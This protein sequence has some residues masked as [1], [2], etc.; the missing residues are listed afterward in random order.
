MENIKQEKNIFELFKKLVDLECNN[1][2]V[3]A[4][5][6]AK[7]GTRL[8][9]NKVNDMSECIVENAKEYGKKLEF[10]NDT[11]KIKSAIEANILRNYALS[12]EKVNKQFDNKRKAIVGEEMRWQARHTVASIQLNVVAK[13][14]DEAKKAPEYLQEKQLQEQA[15]MAIDE[16]D[17]ETLS[18]INKELTEISMRNPATKLEAQARQIRAE[19]AIIEETIGRCEK[20]IKDCE[21]ERRNSIELIAGKKENLLQTADKKYLLVLKNEGWLQRTWG[22]ILNK[23]NGSK[24][25]TE[26]VTNVLSKKV[27]DIDYKTLPSLKMKLQAETVAIMEENKEAAKK[28]KYSEIKEKNNSKVAKVVKYTV[29]GAKTVSD[30]TKYMA[31]KGKKLTEHIVKETKDTGN[32]ITTQAWQNVNQGYNAM[33]G[34]ARSAKM[35][36]I[37]KM[38]Q[39]INALEQRQMPQMQKT[40]EE[41]E[42]AAQ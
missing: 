42:L 2:K 10:V 1:A 16:G 18:K 14:R 35:W 11:Q 38:E 32:K 24:R 19:L 6:F 31:N 21:I 26:N 29:K 7:K 20:H 12:L 22:K 34:Q 27:R 37:S 40:Q 17:Y 41:P 30:K 8:V 36:T 5:M 15:K 13:M 33:I 25:Y 23:L 9:S 3:E 39:R 28:I 4:I